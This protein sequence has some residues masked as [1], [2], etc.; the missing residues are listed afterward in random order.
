MTGRPSDGIFI[1][2]TA[3]SSSTAVNAWGVSANAD[4]SPQLPGPH[5]SAGGAW[6][7]AVASSVSTSV[8]SEPDGAKPPS[9]SVSVPFTSNAPVSNVNALSS[10]ANAVGSG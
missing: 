7:A 10:A 2:A 4:T 5:G 1:D 8:N 9:A 3:D 6:P